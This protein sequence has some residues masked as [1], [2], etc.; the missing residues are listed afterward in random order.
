VQPV[1]LRYGVGTDGFTVCAAAPD[2]NQR[3]GLAMFKLSNSL[4]VTYLEVY[5]PNEVEIEQPG[6]FAE[7]VRAVMSKELAV[8][9]TKHS[10]EDAWLAS[11]ARRYGVEQTF[12]VDTLTSIFQLDAAGVRELL[13]CFHKLDASGDVRT[14]P[15]LNSF[16]PRA[17]KR[18]HVRLPLPC[19]LV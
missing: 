2:A 15:L 6:T 19:V 8:P 13:D 1:T 5:A 12:E 3:V 10:Y 11:K 18:I 16:G 4:E 14:T 7:S 17:F 9:V